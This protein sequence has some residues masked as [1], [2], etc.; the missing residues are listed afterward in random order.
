VIEVSFNN[1]FDNANDNEDFFKDTNFAPLI[2]G[3]VICVILHSSAN[4]M[5]Q[6]GNASIK[7]AVDSHNAGL[8]EKISFQFEGISNGIGLVEYF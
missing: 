7:S 2:L 5:K 3:S 1:A 6:E 8:K 4:K